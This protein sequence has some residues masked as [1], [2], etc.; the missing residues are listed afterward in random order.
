MNEEDFPHW[1]LDISRWSDVGLDRFLTYQ[2]L[3]NKF[4]GMVSDSQISDQLMS[5]DVQMS[6]IG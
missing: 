6:R 2:N 5:Y 3:V 1:P 4:P